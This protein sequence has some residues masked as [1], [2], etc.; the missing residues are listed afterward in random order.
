VHRLHL[1]ENAKNS[2]EPQRILN[3]A[4]KDV[5]KVEV[6]KLLMPVS[7]TWFLIVY[8]LVQFMLCQRSLKSQ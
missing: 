6:L 8:G 3:P 7:F 4:V 1:E 5:V 2:R